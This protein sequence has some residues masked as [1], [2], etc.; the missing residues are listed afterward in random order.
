MIDLLKQRL[1]NRITAILGFGR[2]GQSSYILIR[3][4]FPD[5]RLIIADRNAAVS[6]HPLL[7]GDPNLEFLE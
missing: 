3:Q 6:D 5:K 2:E 4:A 1:N 7:K